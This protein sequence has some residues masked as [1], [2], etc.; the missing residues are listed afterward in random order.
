MSGLRG[1]EPDRLIGV[2]VRVLETQV[3]PSVA[4]RE[5]RS[6]L[7]LTVGL[8][9]NLGPRVAERAESATCPVTAD[10]RMLSA[11]PDEL[12]AP[13]GIGTRVATDPSALLSSVFRRLRGHADLLELPVSQTWLAL[14]R[15][16]LSEMSATEIALMRPTRYLTSQR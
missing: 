4:D 16:E 6:T 14:C 11:L 15:R 13:L 9:D 1:N 8:L 12:A 3:L 10:Q 7:L 2:L 5:A